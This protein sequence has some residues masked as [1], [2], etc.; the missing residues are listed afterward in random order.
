[1]KSLLSPHIVGLV[2]ESENH[3]GYEERDRVRRRKED[4]G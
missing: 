1:M 2:S 4:L 3:A